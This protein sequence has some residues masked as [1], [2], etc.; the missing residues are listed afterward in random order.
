MSYAGLL[1]HTCDIYRKT[2]STDSSGG[3]VWSWSAVYSDVDC[4]IQRKTGELEYFKGGE[5]IT[6]DAIG[7]YL[8]TQDIQVGDLVYHNA[9]EYY[10][11]V[12]VENAA[13]RDHHYE[14]GLK[15]TKEKP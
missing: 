10:I 9:S 1:L 12:F 6:Y 3:S 11:V 7:F 8:F 5:N 4:T 13:D 14:V 2:K 15:H